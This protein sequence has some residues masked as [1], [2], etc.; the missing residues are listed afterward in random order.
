MHSKPRSVAVRFPSIPWEAG[1][2]IS[3]GDNEFIEVDAPTILYGTCPAGG[4]SV[5]DAL[6]NLSVPREVVILNEK[7]PDSAP[8]FPCV[9]SPSGIFR[10]T[11]LPEGIHRDD[12]D[13]SKNADDADREEK[14]NKGKTP[15]VTDRFPLHIDRKSVV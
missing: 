2:K 14:F 12:R 4:N 5:L 10:Q 7:L 8:H 13:C 15:V 11:Q 3:L 9:I 1:E 6:R